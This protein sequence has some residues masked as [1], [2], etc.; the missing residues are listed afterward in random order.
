MKKLS[1]WASRNKWPARIL[2]VLSLQLLNITGIITGILLKDVGILLPSGLF[3]LVTLVYL[4]GIYFYPRKEYK[5]LLSPKKFYIRQKFCDGLLAASAFFMFVCISN[6]KTPFHTYFSQYSR[7]SAS[8]PVPVT[9]KDSSFNS[10]RM[11]VS[12]SRSMKDNEGHLLKWKERK[13]LLRQQLQLI[14]HSTELSAG[15]KTGLTILCVLVAIGLI[16]LALGLA[17]NLSCNGHDGGAVLVGVGGT[18]LVIF[19]FIIAIRSIY[20][21]KRKKRLEAIRKEEAKGE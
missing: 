2:L 12:F 5:A 9:F 18:A 19:L 20:P 10:F 13:K 1:R 17:C 11:L 21:G 15:A 3:L 7:V 14:K 16:F 4:A 6:D 8:T